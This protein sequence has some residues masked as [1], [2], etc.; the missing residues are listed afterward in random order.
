MTPSLEGWPT[1]AKEAPSPQEVRLAPLDTNSV[2]QSLGG[3]FLILLYDNLFF[4]LT[5]KEQLIF[6]EILVRYCEILLFVYLEVHKQFEGALQ[7]YF[8]KKNLDVFLKAYLLESILKQFS[9]IYKYLLTSG[10]EKKASSE[11]LS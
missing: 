11:V 9:N 7:N 2:F 4:S 10:S 1:K 3:D 6:R 8:L 5:Y